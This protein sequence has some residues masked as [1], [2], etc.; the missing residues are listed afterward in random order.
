MYLDQ[1]LRSESYPFFS[2]QIRRQMLQ[3][4]SRGQQTTKQCNL[5]KVLCFIRR[6]RRTFLHA[7]PFFAFVDIN[8]QT[9]YIFCTFQ[10]F[11]RHF[12]K[13]CAH[14][15]QSKLCSGEWNVNNQMSNQDFRLYHVA[16]NPSWCSKSMCTPLDLKR[17]LS[18][19]KPNPTL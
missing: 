11:V 16:G 3:V 8:L 5:I 18:L 10:I 19:M 13:I 6:L 15:L 9:F 7:T 4:L 14:A 17:P 1:L 2:R 12:G